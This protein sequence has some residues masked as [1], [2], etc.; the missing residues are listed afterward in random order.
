MAEQITRWKKCSPKSVDSWMYE[1]NAFKKIVRS[2]YKYV[3]N[4]LSDY[5]RLDKEQKAFY[6]GQV[7]ENNK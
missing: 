7:L 2:R 4:Y 5:F 6:F 3:I 1:V